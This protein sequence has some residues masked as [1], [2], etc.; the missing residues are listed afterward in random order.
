MFTEFHGYIDLEVGLKCGPYDISDSVY[1]M[2]F[3]RIKP[4]C[5]LSG[6]ILFTSKVYSINVR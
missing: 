1:N 4:N 5:N 3:C 6:V 2:E